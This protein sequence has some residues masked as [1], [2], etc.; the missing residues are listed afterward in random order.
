ME[1]GKGG[2][3]GYRLW[4]RCL[5]VAT[6]LIQV[7]I[8]RLQYLDTLPVG[9]RTTVLQYSTSVLRYFTCWLSYYTTRAHI[10]GICELAV[11]L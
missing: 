1:R 2:V 4:L 9:C 11:Q 7:F 3:M 8:G 10:S 5:G 6:L